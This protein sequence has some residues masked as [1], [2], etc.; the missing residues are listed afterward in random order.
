MFQNQYCL[1]QLPGQQ[2][3]WTDGLQS[4]AEHSR[5]GPILLDR[6]WG[7]EVKVVVQVNCFKGAMERTKIK[8]AH[9]TGQSNGH[10]YS[11]YRDN[12]VK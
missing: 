11:T 8:Y 6:Q 12:K 2:K 5:Q 3:L 1:P 4:R 7:K 10:Q 9:N